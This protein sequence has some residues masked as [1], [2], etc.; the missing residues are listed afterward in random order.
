MEFIGIF[1]SFTDD[2]RPL[3]K[4]YDDEEEFIVDVVVGIDFIE[5][6]DMEIGDEVRIILQ[7]TS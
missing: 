5:K 2:G 7:K 4:I 1:D 3:F 6:S